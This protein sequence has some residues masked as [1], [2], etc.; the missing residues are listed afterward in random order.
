[1]KENFCLVVRNQFGQY[2]RGDLI[3]NPEEVKKI[4][5]CHEKNMVVKIKK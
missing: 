2:K 1:M 5:E 3:K 4:L